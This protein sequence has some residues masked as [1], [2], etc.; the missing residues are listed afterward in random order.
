MS[1]PRFVVREVVGYRIHPRT[2]PGGGVP[3]LTVWVGDEAYN[4]REIKMWRSEDYGPM[5]RATRD[6]LMRSEAKA[7]AAQL[8]AG[9]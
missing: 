1:S 8:N 4:G 6:A 3:G 5:W 9:G 7:L 2:G